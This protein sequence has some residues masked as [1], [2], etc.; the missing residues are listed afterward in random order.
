MKMSA[1]RIY[2]IWLILMLLGYGIPLA[3][4]MFDPNFGV[5][6]FPQLLLILFLWITSHRFHAHARTIGLITAL[7]VSLI[8]TF[9]SSLAIGQGI[10]AGVPWLI[11]AVLA[12]SC[13]MSEFQRTQNQVQK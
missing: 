10:L 2:T 7:I 9:R 13:V 11:V 5:L 4:L 8:V 1:E 3:I 12:H 6:L